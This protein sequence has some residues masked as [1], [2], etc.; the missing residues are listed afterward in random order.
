M[1]VALGEGDFDVGGAEGLVDI[2]MHFMHE[3]GPAVT[4]GDKNAE[5]KI[6]GAF[7]ESSEDGLRF[8][9]VQNERRVLGDLEEEI[10]CF[11]GVVSVGDSNWDDDASDRIG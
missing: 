11:L 8:G 10:S 7:A 1:D 4:V 5:F 9:I 3:F 6:E 2:R